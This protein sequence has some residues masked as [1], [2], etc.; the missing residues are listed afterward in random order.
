MPPGVRTKQRPILSSIRPMC[1]L[2]SVVCVCV[3]VCVMSRCLSRVLVCLCWVQSDEFSVSAFVC[4]RA[5]R[6][7]AWQAVGLDANQKK[8]A[9]PYKNYTSET[10]LVWDSNPFP[11]CPF[12]LSG[13][14]HKLLHVPPRYMWGWAP[15]AG[16]LGYCGTE[17]RSGE[18]V[19][20]HR[21]SMKKMMMMMLVG[22]REGRECCR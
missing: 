21:M 9:V 19:N 11:N 2:T 4:I 6:P 17:W 20:H 14:T 13:T 8:V 16:V 1:A 3:C 18:R 7:L 12:A 5:C 10:G 22:E 15:V